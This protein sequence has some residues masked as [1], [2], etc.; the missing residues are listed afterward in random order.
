MAKSLNKNRMLGS[1]AALAVAVLIVLFSR[2]YWPEESPYHEILET[3]GSVMI[4]LCAMGR[5]YASVFLGGHKNQTL[6]THGI[7]AVLRNPLY[8]FS[9]LGITGIAMI[10]NHISVMIGLPLFFLFLYSGLIRREQDFLQKEFGKEYESYKNNVASLIPNFS[11][12]NAP[13]SMTIHPHFVGKA[14]MDSIWWL[15]AL[16]IIELCEYLQQLKIIPVLFAG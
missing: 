7:Y 5:L 16:P 1:K 4:G 3:T 10:S 14:F 12:Y 2:Q 15:A 8:F 13:D 6:I 11:N 9:L